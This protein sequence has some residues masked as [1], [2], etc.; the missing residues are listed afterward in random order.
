[1]K[2]GAALSDTAEAGLA[3]AEAAD[4]AA[5]ALEGSSC[6]LALAFVAPSHADEL[7][8]VAAAVEARLEP[9]ALIG[10]VAQG[11]VGP[12]TEAED[13]P[14]VAVWC[15]SFGGHVQPFRSH[16]VRTPDGAMAVV[17]WP[18][19]APDDV[20]LLLA[21]PFTYPAGEVV[22]RIGEERPG[23]RL[24]GGLVTPGQRGSS[25]LILHQEVHDD[26][27]VGAVLSGVDV[28]TVVSQGCRPVGEPYVVTRAERNH[29]L[30]LG[31][32]PAAK[33]LQEVYDTASEDDRRLLRQGIHIGIVADEYRDEFD[34]GD[35]LVRGVLG[36]DAD[37]GAVIVG[38]VVEVGH[39]VQFH[40]RDAESAHADLKRHLE[41][42]GRDAAGALLF[43]CNGRG[44]RF[45][46]VEDHDA[47]LVGRCL[48]DRLAGAFC[49]GEI[50]PV[51]RRSFLHGF[52]ASLA[53]FN[54]SG[55][56]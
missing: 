24:V 11:V 15:A 1:M 6:S 32:V 43:T 5:Q 19:T 49:A 50:G 39:T 36:A 53:V 22:G 34:T 2:A 40:V 14:A 4:A 55:D 9:S 54:A 35:F 13:G 42:Y 28:E 48:T 47:G 38:D 26:G 25:R 18:D 20:V 51:G 30:E 12:G 8:D 3:A 56:T 33:R 52:T 16:A 37:S 7:S 46:G 31:G 21:D 27:A 23:N 41:A 29:L 10:A 17:G 44:R 45:F